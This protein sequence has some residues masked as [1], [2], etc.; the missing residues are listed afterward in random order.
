MQASERLHKFNLSC[1]ITHLLHFFYRLT[2]SYQIP[3]L[4]KLSVMLNMQDLER[5]VLLKI[6]E[7]PKL[8]YHFSHHAEEFLKICHF[9]IFTEVFELG[10]ID[11][12]ANQR[13][14]FITCINYLHFYIVFVSAGRQT[15]SYCDKIYGEC[16]ALFL[17]IIPDEQEMQLEL[18]FC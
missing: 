18:V 15:G 10:M 13:V 8:F 3:S 17:K 6:P 11:I 7:N 16:P 1:L 9:A 4:S 14:N 12:K 2:Y 5:Q